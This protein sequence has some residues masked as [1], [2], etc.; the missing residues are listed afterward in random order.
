VTPPATWPELHL[1][2]LFYD[3][4]NSTVALLDRI[5]RRFQ[6]PTPDW[7]VTVTAAGNDATALG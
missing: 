1:S 6:E 2:G 7:P 5:G 3:I 4:G